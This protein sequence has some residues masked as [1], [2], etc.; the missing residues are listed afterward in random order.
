M[1]PSCCHA[2]TPV[3]PV[4]GADDLAGLN[5]IYPQTG[6]VC[7]Y[8]INPTSVNV[9]FSTT[10]GTV[11]VT[12][13]SGCTW[14]ASGGSGFIS[15]TSGAVGQRFRASRLQ[16]RRQQRDH[17]ANRHADDRGIDVHGQ[18]G[19]SAVYVRGQSHADRSAG[20]R[21]ERRA[22]DH[23]VVELQLDGEQ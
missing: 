18:P 11:Q 22:D 20:G 12:T 9:P 1:Y 10:T 6:Q 14:N 8:A 15:V 4:I 17:G 16:R 13:Q 3:P 7:T 21:L 2:D 19:S 5:Y 23:D